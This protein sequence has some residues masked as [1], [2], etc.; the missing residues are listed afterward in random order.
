LDLVA[1][2]QSAWLDCTGSVYSLAFS[3]DG[4]RLAGFAAA[5]LAVWDLEKGG[6]VTNAFEDGV[7]N[8]TDGVR[9][10]WSSDGRLIATTGLLDLYAL[11]PP[12]PI[13]VR[14]AATSRKLFALEGHTTNAWKPD[15]SPDSRL[16]A[17]PHADGS[18]ILWDLASRQ[19]RKTFGR[20]GN[21]VACV[22][23]SPD[24]QWLAS[25]SMDETVRLWRVDGDEQIP[26][27]SHAR[28]V[29]CVAFS[30]DGRWLASGSRDH[31]AK[32]W[33]LAS[34]TTKPLTLRGHTGRLWSIDFTPDSQA[35]VTGSLDGTV[36]LWDVGRLRNQRR[37][38]DNRTSL[39]NRVLTRGP[40]EPA[41]G[42]HQR[43]H[44]RGG[45]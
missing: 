26:L 43:G 44:P 8:A 17:T 2:C 41:W 36:K 12:G 18:V 16:L 42:G 13:I 24:G 15:F 4:K 11:A 19:R 25:A 33:D 40:A 1:R 7:E 31:T 23:F 21:I 9:V 10:A 35:L 6:V 45:L 22:R 14:D 29:D 5:G 30:P 32:L 39:G 38:M 20:H 28:P 37:Q 27:G 34:L 3:P